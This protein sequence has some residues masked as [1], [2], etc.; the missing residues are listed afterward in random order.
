[1]RTIHN[2]MMN[3][4]KIKLSS[5]HLLV[6]AAVALISVGC[7]ADVDSEL[8]YDIIPDHQ[9]M[10][11]R[12]LRFKGGKVI[13]FNAATSTEDKS[14]YIEREGKFF[15]TSLY[16]TDSLL[17]SNVNNGYIG[18]EH[19]D[20]FGMRSSALASS[21]IFMNSVDKETGFGYKPIFDTMT[22][23]LTINDYGVDTL[24]PV[25]YEIYELN[26]PLLGSVVNAADTSAYSNC[27]MES[28]YDSS[29]PLF[30]FTF[31]D[32]E[33]TGPNTR[34]IDLTPVDMSRNGQTWDFVRRMML[35]PEDYDTNKE[36]DGYAKDTDSLYSSEKKWQ[37][38]FHGIYIKPVLESVD[39]TKRG[40]LY[41][42]DLK[43]S[44]LQLMGR[45]RNPKDPTLIQDT[46]GANY[47][48]YDETLDGYRDDY[49]NFI[50]GPED[51]L[52]ISVN[53]IKHDYSG[54]L[55]DGID[56]AAYDKDGK[57][58]PNSARDEV[59][60]CYVEG[61]A[62]VATEIYFTDE[63]L[64]ELKRASYLD[65]ENADTK[66]R[67]VGINQCR[68]YVYLKGADYNWDENIN[69]AHLLTPL[70]NNSI[71]RLGSYIG[72]SKLNCIADYDPEYETNY[73]TELSYGGYLNR[74]RGCYEM[75]ITGFMQRL[76]NYVN[77]LEKIEDYDETVTPRAIYL[78]PEAISPY[79]FKHTELQGSTSNR[80]PIHLEMTYTMVK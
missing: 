63:F 79:T 44:G 25:R 67:A 3:C 77:S 7:S 13:V 48:F 27:T 22:L 2:S 78:G 52:N 26:K 6:L 42:F 41:S 30:T 4:L 17:S 5:L 57:K 69:N 38:R 53:S 49:G 76:Y 75:D 40:S 28:A 46:I 65:P 35:I 9:K 29:K 12:H 61:F 11:M 54:S 20:T 73:N 43:S 8:G 47:Y 72:Y 15:R 31:P 68:L 70:M 45:N 64:A 55:L 33:K 60:E 71:T 34:T 80:A 58:L 51:V 21:I 10:E 14:E 16:H 32:G 74:S 19:N 59:A 50:E 66:Y 62:G 37:Q 1:M 23:V 18:V 24:T 39:K 36:W 56:F